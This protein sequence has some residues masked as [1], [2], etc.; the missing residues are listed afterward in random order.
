MK[1]VRNV[2]LAAGVVI[3]IGMTGGGSLAT[4][5]QDFTTEEIHGLMEKAMR[6]CGQLNQDLKAMFDRYKEFD[7]KKGQAEV[8]QHQELMKRLLHELQ[9]HMEDEVHMLAQLKAMGAGH[10]G[11][12]Q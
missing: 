12:H 7:G 10:E 2:V 8:R 4:E 9:S 3:C 1:T 11:H 5:Q 6:D